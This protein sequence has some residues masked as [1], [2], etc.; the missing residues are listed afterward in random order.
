MTYHGSDD[1]E[2]A[3]KCL[4]KQLA[5]WDNLSRSDSMDYAQVLCFL[6]EIYRD[7]ERP[8]EAIEALARGIKLH[9][10]A[11]ELEDEDNDRY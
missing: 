2:N 3:S 7:M 10:A 1:L 4:K 8:A 5:I 6:G 9:E 11:S